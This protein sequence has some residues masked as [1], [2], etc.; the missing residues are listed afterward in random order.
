MSLPS[1][2]GRSQ[3]LAGISKAVT[4][5]TFAVVT[6]SESGLERPLVASR[7][8]ALSDLSRHPAASERHAAGRQQQ[9]RQAE[10]DETAAR[11]H[12]DAVPP[13]TRLPRAHLRVLRRIRVHAG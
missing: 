4:R 13:T 9:R 12:P 3:S 8:S 5:S 6:R 2:L 1:E 7:S 11:V 10:E